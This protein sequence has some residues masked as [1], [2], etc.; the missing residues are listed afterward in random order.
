MVEVKSYS[1]HSTSSQSHLLAPIG[2]GFELQLS[3][4]LSSL[5][6]Y[7]PRYIG[8][9]SGGFE[10][11]E[12]FY[13]SNSYCVEWFRLPL[14]KIVYPTFKGSTCNKARWKFPQY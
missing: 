12:R 7:R 4:F 3:L 6:I 9:L 8:W 10:S 11:D 13:L 2:I 1:P 5:P 14:P